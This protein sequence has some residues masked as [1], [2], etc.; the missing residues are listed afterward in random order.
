M[1]YT[2]M[3]AWITLFGFGVLLLGF[4]VWGRW[5]LGRLAARRAEV[6]AMV[7]HHRPTGSRRAPR[8]SFWKGESQRSIR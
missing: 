2:D 1:S 7:A 4:L 6:D 3:Y 5:R 8:Q